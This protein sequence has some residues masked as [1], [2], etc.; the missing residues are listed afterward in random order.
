MKRNLRFFVMLLLVGMLSSCSDDKTPITEEPPKENPTTPEEE[1][2]DEESALPVLTVVGRC[3]KNNKG[4]IVNLHGFA[5]TYSPYFNQNAWNNYDVS[6]CLSYNKRLIDQMQSAGWKFNFIR[7]HLDPYWSD[8]TSKES[9]R[10]EG[11]ERFSSARFQKY[12]DELFI[13]MA[14]YAISKGLYIVMRPPGV[15]PEKIAVGDDYQKFL[16][17]VWNIVSKH[18]DIKNNMDIMF[19][20]ANEPIH[21]LGPDG[22]YAG[23]GSGHFMNLKSYFQTIT[24]KVRA[25]GAKNIIWVP[26]LSYQSS[27]SGYATYPIEGENIGYAVHVYP[28]WYGSD[29]QSPSAEL[30][31]VMGGGYDGFQRGWDAQVMPVANFAPIMITEMDWAPEKY[32][33][34]WGK[35]ITGEV[36][37]TGFGANFKYIMD[38]TGNASWLL[39][40][41]P[42]LLAQFKNVAGTEGNYAFLNDPEACPWPVYHW[43]KEYAGEA[44]AEGDLNSLQVAGVTNSLSIR[45]G[46]SKNFIVK[47]LY[48]DGTTRVVT[49]KSSVSSSNSA[50]LQV[51]NAGKM[52]AVKEGLAQV[53]ISYTSA[54]GVTKQL[55]L[56]VNVI[57]PFPLTATMF[58]PSIWE[59]G[60]FDEGT[61]TLVTG[62]YGFGGWEYANGLNLSAFK[63]L[64]IEL[65]NDNQSSVSFRL[66][67]KTSYW[68]DPATY[69]FGSSRK[70]VVDL[71]N[72]KDKN[73][74][75]IDP[76]HLYIIGF[77]STGDKPIVI[78][79]VLLNY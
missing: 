68:T 40:T 16:L 26:G 73:G 69:D 5:Q 11:H 75:R 52:V 43:F 7:M 8:D 53:T 12:L 54:K 22:T 1:T 25:N 51:D 29:A 74:L 39:F 67:D 47:A 65:G 64:T 72:M 23:T 13:P 48:V 19:E 6:G 77:W 37:G 28:G 10:Y 71:Q 32:N 70:V 55:V 46:D 27:Y 50:V 20:L 63:T 79:K 56:T 78:D 38:R 33:S 61:R 41:S 30:G 36:G 59:K 31:G 45:M 4:E 42:H 58:N 21:I 35:S 14:K 66:F 2:T 34:S 15:A 62:K 60:T 18:P 49:S 44:P 17:T 9:V 76:S 3:L 24:D 57:T